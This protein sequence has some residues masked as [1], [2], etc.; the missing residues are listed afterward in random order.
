MNLS[1]AFLESTQNIGYVSGK[2]SKNFLKKFRYFRNSKE[3]I[4]RNILSILGKIPKEMRTEYFKRRILK[5][6]K[7]Q[8][9]F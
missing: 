5:Q 6:N 3:K 7:F 1:G 9:K 2:C 4:I 8:K